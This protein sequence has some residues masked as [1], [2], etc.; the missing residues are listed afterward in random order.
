[1]CIVCGIYSHYF[2]KKNYV[3][4]KKFFRK[5]IFYLLNGLVIGKL[6]TL[7]KLIVFIEFRLTKNCEI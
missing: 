5:D 7:V 2:E 3:L 6:L 1:M 4:E